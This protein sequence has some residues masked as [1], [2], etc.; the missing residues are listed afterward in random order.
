MRLLL[1]RYCSCSHVRDKGHIH[2]IGVGRSI[3]TQWVKRSFTCHCKLVSK[4]QWANLKTKGGSKLVS[5]DMD[6]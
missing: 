2:G 6:I 5:L 3:E 1:T 4:M